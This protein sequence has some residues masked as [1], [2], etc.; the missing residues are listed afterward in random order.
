M[1]IVLPSDVQS[2]IMHK[3]DIKDLA[4]Y[5]LTNKSAY[6]VY[7]SKYFWINK[8]SSIP[9]HV[10]RS[11]GRLS[12]F[13][14]K[15]CQLCLVEVDRFM[16]ILYKTSLEI[17]ISGIGDLHIL[18][19]NDED[20]IKLAF[21]IFVGK[22]NISPD[23]YISYHTNKYSMFNNDPPEYY[24]V[25]TSFWD[26]CMKDYGQIRNIIYLAVYYHKPLVYNKDYYDYYD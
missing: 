18:G 9:F 15:Y 12:L 19:I 6:E 26:C 2:M 16:D 24:L 22:S 13:E 10:E 4:N 23:I 20:I 17:H 5:V 8:F 7:Q 1:A 11:T 14:Y 21:I 3:L 25:S